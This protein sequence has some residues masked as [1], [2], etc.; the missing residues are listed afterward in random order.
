M[1][2]C[3]LSP[4]RGRL[5]AVL[6]L[7]L[8]LATGSPP[9][10]ASASSTP[11]AA[12]RAAQAPEWALLDGSEPALQLFAPSSG[13]LFART[14]S[15]LKRS[16]DGGI[17]WHPVDLPPR[18]D[19][20]KRIVVEVDPSDHTRLFANGADGLYRSIDDA[21]TW[22]PLPLPT[23]TGSS[24]RSIAVSPAD[25]AL[26]Y[27][28]KVSGEDVGTTLWTVRS[29]DG[30]DTWELVKRDDAGPSCGYRVDLFAPHP[31]D[32]SRVYRN[33]GCTRGG[34]GGGPLEHSAD[35]G[36]TWTDLTPPEAGG[37]NRIVGG[38]AV[39]GRRFYLATRLVPK[40]AS[41]LYESE[42]GVG[43]WRRIA[44]A[45]VDTIDALADDPR[46]PNRV[47]VGTSDGTVRAL[48]GGDQQWA[49]LGQQ[50]LGA[51]HDLVLGVDGANLYAATEQGIW[52][53]P[54]TPT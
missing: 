32:P 15:G 19:F 54:L 14:A 17:I 45:R 29:G 39:A 33:V 13:A 49:L 8:A 31:T 3:P 43:D 11:G 25:R 20:Q 5:L 40:T 10:A 28:S 24:I 26:V 1:P 27:V 35:Q 48:V 46:N 34:P 38:R 53:Y 16:D 4:R 47:Y 51:I 6:L 44:E 41:R 37:P 42:D 2:C 52:R 9:G 36:V 7:L 23:G 12:T 22:T 50:G 30:G 18:K 21:Q